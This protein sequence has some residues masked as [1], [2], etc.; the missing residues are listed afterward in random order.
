MTTIA[1]ALPLKPL[2]VRSLYLAVVLGCLAYSTFESGAAEGRKSRNEP[3]KEV[4]VFRGTLPDRTFKELEVYADD[5]TEREEP[6]ITEK[7]RKKARKRGADALI[8][9]P[10]KPSGAALVPFSGF[11]STFTYRATAVSFTG[12]PGSAPRFSDQA[13]PP[14]GSAGTPSAGRELVGAGTGFFITEDGYL[15]TNAHV[16]DDG[17]EYGVLVSGR[18]HVGT[19]VR[20]DAGTD[21]ALLKL[22]GRF[23]PL[24]I[25]S[26]RSVKLGE[27][28]FTVGFPRPS[29][30]GNEPKLTRG[31]ISAL[32]GM[33]DNPRDFQISAPI[34]PG[35]S[36]GALVDR[37]GNVLGVVVSTINPIRT[38]Q[39]TG[40]LPQN[41]NYAI[42]SSFL[43][44]FIESIPAMQQ[45]SLPPV[46][47]GDI[48]E[49]RAIENAV[50]AAVM[51]V[52]FRSI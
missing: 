51:V 27:P 20:A 31:D 52:V 25:R 33:Q 40:S 3:E 23:T 24:P 1:V 10:L 18:M 37:R 50:S 21:L 17:N 43:L 11:R 48:P 9:A 4:E 47:D 39:T 2:L 16:V 30:Q 41:V 19:L 28:V 26:S 22:D 32:S 42:T 15:I 29:I 49:E 13:L 38:L 14:V 36:G 8:V 6:E 45:S 12:P 34:Q 7:Y 46:V 44:A 35:N 5:I